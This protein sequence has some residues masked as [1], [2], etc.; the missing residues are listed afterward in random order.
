MNQITRDQVMDFFRNDTEAS[1]NLHS[2]SRN[3]KYE[4]IMQLA[5]F[6]DY[7]SIE[8]EL[9]IDDYESDNK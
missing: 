2:L 1:D 5:S 9:I 3:D 6:S 8:F 7:L 4:L